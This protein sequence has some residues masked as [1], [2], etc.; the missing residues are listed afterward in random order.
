MHIRTR[1]CW[2]PPLHRRGKYTYYLFNFIRLGSFQLN[3]HFEN[4]YLKMLAHF[5]INILK[6]S[7]ALKFISIA[8]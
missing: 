4:I 5:R 2:F 6:I 1:R 7:L 3:K 8:H